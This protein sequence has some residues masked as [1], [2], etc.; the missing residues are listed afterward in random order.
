MK[1]SVE[2]LQVFVSIVDSGS[3]VKAAAQLQQAPSQLS[4]ML[5]RLEQ[6]LGVTLLDRS[7]RKLKLSHEGQLFLHRA[8]KI[9]ADLHAAEEEIL[10]FDEQLCGRIRIDSATPFV[11]QVLVPLMHEFM[12]R[13]PQLQIELN[14]H[15]HNID[16][17]AQ[18]TDVAI[19]FGHLSD[20]SLH[21]KLLGYSQFCLVASPDYLARMGQPQQIADLQQH[22]LI[23]FSQLEYLNDWPLLEHNELLHVQPRIKA[24]SGETV[25]QLAL[26][27][28][29]IAC[30]S[31]FVISQDL[32]QGRL[33][34]VLPELTQP[35]F[36]AIQAV[37]YRQQYLPKRVQVFLEFLAQRLSTVLHSESAIAQQKT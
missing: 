10:K 28:S 7:T 32:L 19:R 18:K 2:E 6:K 14:T 36:I 4:R 1:S 25:R 24:S 31:H 17:L 3:M 33:L 23:G 15:D 35:R 16:L 22:Q 37:Y 30:L 27:G 9:L 5:Q 8:R 20:S 21:A 13:H 34:P 29:G 11:L 26:Q 12:Q